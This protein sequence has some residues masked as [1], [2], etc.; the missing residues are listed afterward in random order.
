M[1]ANTKRIIITL[2]LI[3]SSAVISYYYYLIPISKTF[4]SGITAISD[5]FGILEIYPTKPGG[6]EWFINMNSPT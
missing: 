2:A 1:G 5:K 3:M 6:R 4:S